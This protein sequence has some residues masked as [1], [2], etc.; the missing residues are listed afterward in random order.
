M[1]F[2]FAGTSGG[3]QTMSSG[4]TSLILLEG[5]S[6][7]LV[8]VSGSP[9]GALA[10]CGVDPVHLGAVILTH[11]HI[12]H[13]YALPSLLHNLWLMGRTDPLPIIGSEPTLDIAQRLCGLFALERKPGIFAFDW[14]RIGPGSELDIGFFTVTAFAARHG[15]PTL[16]LVISA[17][18][19]KLVY[20]ADTA[21]LDS[22]LLEAAGAHVIVHEAAGLKDREESHNASGHSSARQAALA[23]TAIAGMTSNAIFPCLML[24]HLPPEPRRVEEMRL[25]ARHFYRGT[26]LIPETLHLYDTAELLPAAFTDSKE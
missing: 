16:G 8:D 17:G 11:A 26:V 3:I 4:N 19:E 21:P 18:G 23:A 5:E 14:K 7:L 15:I 9:A 6:S 10:A 24:C 12:D 20:S 13:M 22:W 1:K 25:E 2:A